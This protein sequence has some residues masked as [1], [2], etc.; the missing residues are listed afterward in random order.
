MKSSF[1]WLCYETL[2]ASFGWQRKPGLERRTSID[3]AV[4]VASLA[5]MDAPSLLQGP[6]ARRQ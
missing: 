3:R 4:S 6:F 5:A 1:C 2:D